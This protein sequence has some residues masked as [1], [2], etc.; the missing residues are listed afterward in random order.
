MFWTVLSLEGYQQIHIP[1]QKLLNFFSRNEN[2][3]YYKIITPSVDFFRSLLFMRHVILAFCTTKC[4]YS[5]NDSLNQYHKNV[6]SVFSLT[7]ATPEMAE[8]KT[9]LCSPKP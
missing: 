1:W 2:N 6:D 4:L 3:S 8:G 7:L 9:S 5:F